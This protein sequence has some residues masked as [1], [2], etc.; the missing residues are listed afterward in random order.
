[1]GILHSSGLLFPWV[2]SLLCNGYFSLQLQS[3]RQKQE[4]STNFRP[5]AG[6]CHR[7]KRR[8]KENK[9]P[10]R[11]ETRQKKNDIYLYVYLHMK[12]KTTVRSG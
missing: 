11:G 1:M 12:T 3:L 7:S 8:Q 4:L 9:V 10:K 5:E 2:F 6:R